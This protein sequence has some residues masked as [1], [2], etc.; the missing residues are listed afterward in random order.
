ME[1][2]FSAATAKRG[3]VV[4]NVHLDLV[5]FSIYLG[6]EDSNVNGIPR[7]M[8][9]ETLDNLY[10]KRNVSGPYLIKVD[11]QGYED[12]VIMG[13]KDTLIRV[14]V[15]IVETSFYE[16]YEG[17]PLFSATYE[18]L[19]KHGFV[20]SGSWGELKSPLDGAPLQQDSIFIRK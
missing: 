4:I 13:A 19:S 20:Y 14:K 1:Y 5:G 18:L 8:P 7:T 12:K 15:I 11:V 6:R 9:A 16:L 10:E 3:E 2:V 17:Q